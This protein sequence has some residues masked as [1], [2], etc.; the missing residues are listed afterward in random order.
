L[1]VSAVLSRALRLTAMLTTA[2][3]VTV[4]LRRY[5]APFRRYAVTP[6]RE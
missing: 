4:V 3:T 2:L 5:G 1:R 6:L